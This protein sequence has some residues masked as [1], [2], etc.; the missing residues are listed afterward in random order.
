[1]NFSAAFIKGKIPIQK[2]INHPPAKCVE[3]R[4]PFQFQ[5]VLPSVSQAESARQYASWRISNVLTVVFGLGRT[6]K[7]HIVELKFT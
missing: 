5:P 6:V 4:L 3:M 7:S 2:R 1:M